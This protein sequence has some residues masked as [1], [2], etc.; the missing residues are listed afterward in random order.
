MT[1]APFSSCPPLSSAAII[2]PCCQGVKPAV[3]IAAQSC[4]T[5]PRSRGVTPAAPIAA[6]YAEPLLAAKSLLRL[7]HRLQYDAGP[8][9]HRV[10]VL[11]RPHGHGRL[12]SRRLL[13]GHRVIRQQDI[14]RRDLAGVHQRAPLAAFHLGKLQQQGRVRCRRQQK[15]N[16]DKN[17]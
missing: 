15:S 9:Q 12:S 16:S 11:G 4:R 1:R 6:E 2:A 10:L 13:G 3:L 17:S 7:R 5:T 14:K 8:R